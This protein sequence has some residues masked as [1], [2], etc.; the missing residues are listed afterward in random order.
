MKVSVTIDFSALEKKIIAFH[1]GHDGEEATKEDIQ[2]FIKN[3]VKHALEFLASDY[4]NLSA[5]G[6]T[7]PIRK[8]NYI[9]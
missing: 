9:L 5:H 3:A 1:H 6:K 4:H 8:S 2:H 7:I